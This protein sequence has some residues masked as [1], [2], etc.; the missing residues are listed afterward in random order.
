MRKR[1][2][3]SNDKP[4]TTTV[5]I[6]PED[7]FDDDIDRNVLRRYSADNSFQEIAIAPGKARTASIAKIDEESDLL[8]IKYV[9]PEKKQVNYTADVHGITKIINTFL[10][11]NKKAH[12][13]TLQTCDIR[14]GKYIEPLAKM[15]LFELQ[16]MER[17]WLKEIIIVVPENHKVEHEVKDSYA[18]VHRYLMVY[19]VVRKK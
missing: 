5:W 11:K 10:S 2:I 13:I 12:Y 17:L 6:F 4:E 18:I 7:T 16:G 9:V 8:Y 19:E 15:V 3:L 14:T 1:K